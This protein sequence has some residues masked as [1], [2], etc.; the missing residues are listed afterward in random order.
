MH[1]LILAAASVAA[2]SAIGI[3]VALRSTLWLL[4]FVAFGAFVVAAYNL[5]LF[6][7]VFHSDLWFAV[8]WG[9]F[10]VLTAY[11]ASA[12]RLRVAAVAA[13]AFGLMSSLAQRRLSTQVRLVRR[14]VESVTGEARLRDG[15]R[16]PVDA[17]LLA[18][19]PEA[20]L[21]ALAAGMALLAAALLLFRAA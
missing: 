5:E 17:E 8:A 1:K 21:Q 11:F 13:A 20:A 9:A 14:R 6:G 10:P 7:G 4:V 16:L 2:A 15:S 3:V 18:R 12:E 19:A